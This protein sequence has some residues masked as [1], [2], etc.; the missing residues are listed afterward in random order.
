MATE[1]KP[2]LTIREAES[3]FSLTITPSKRTV[4]VG[5][6]ITFAVQLKNEGD[7]TKSNVNISIGL[8]D[9]LDAQTAA[10][11]GGETGVIDCDV[12]EVGPG[13]VVG[14]D[15]YVHIGSKEPNGSVT[16]WAYNFVEPS[17]ELA[18]ARIDPLTIRDPI[19]TVLVL[20]KE[21]S[22][23]NGWVEAS[24]SGFEPGSTITVKWHGGRVLFTRTADNSGRASGGFRTPLEPI[25]NYTVS[26]SDSEGNKATDTLRVIPRIKL[27]A[28]VPPPDSG[29][30]G[31]SVRVY[32]YGFNPGDRVEIQWYSVSGAEY[33]VLKTIT[34][35]ANGRGTTLITIPNTARG[36]HLIRGKVI[37]VSRS[38]STYF[39]VT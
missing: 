27:A 17:E 8:P 35:A 33:T 21:K 10:C 16:A 24:L 30:P 26:A 38:A 7:T 18:N 3:K 22:K 4:V 13:D 1:S 32:L 20:S 34:I 23:Y 29:P 14:V 25:G 37:G 31:K 2:P 39:T 15:F 12:G 36:A 28:S 19:K 9:A 11:P 6:I 5:E